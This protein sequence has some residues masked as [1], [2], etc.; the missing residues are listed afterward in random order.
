M[1]IGTI[2][3]AYISPIHRHHYVHCS[4]QK[5]HQHH[6]PKKKSWWINSSSCPNHSVSNITVTKVRLPPA[7]LLFF[8]FRSLAVVRWPLQVLRTASTKPQ[9]SICRD[10]REVLRL[11]D[12]RSWNGGNLSHLSFTMNQTW[13]CKKMP[14][15]SGCPF[16]KGV[17]TWLDIRN[18][19]TIANFKSSVGP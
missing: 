12:L 16:L 4:Q 7:F 13:K 11:H 19:E 1:Q 5:T 10:H 14:Q 3:Q 17:D 8:I 15:L 9:D 18:C 6:K 2:M